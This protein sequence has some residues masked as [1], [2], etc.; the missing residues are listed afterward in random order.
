[1][2]EGNVTVSHSYDSNETALS[3]C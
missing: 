2:S 1:M 3:P